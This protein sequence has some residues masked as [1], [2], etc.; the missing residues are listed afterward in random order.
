MDEGANT[1]DGRTKHPII[2]FTNSW[3]KA[4]VKKLN[5]NNNGIID[6][7]Y[8]IFIPLPTLN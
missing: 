4:K 6:L 8:I 2:A 3:K 7:N 1:S 5:I